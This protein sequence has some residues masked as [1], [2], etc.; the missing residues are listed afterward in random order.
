MLR[1][2][3]FLLMTTVVVFGDQPLKPPIEVQSISGEVDL[4][5]CRTDITVLLDE[6]KREFLALS[7]SFSKQLAVIKINGI[8]YKLKQ[9]EI[10]PIRGQKPAANLPQFIWANEQVRVEV[11][12]SASPKSSSSKS[13]KSEYSELD[14]FSGK[15]LVKLGESLRSYK[16]KGESGC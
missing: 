10:R 7:Y 4:N 13:E 8:S 2:I 11:F 9:L 3:A 16:I 14:E 1:N 6:G 15:M 12:F 5:D